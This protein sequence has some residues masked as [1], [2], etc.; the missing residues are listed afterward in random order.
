MHG[1]QANIFYG[2][3]WRISRTAKWLAHP[4]HP[5]QQRVLCPC[6]VEQ[7]SLLREWR[8]WGVHVTLPSSPTAPG[9]ALSAPR[10]APRS[11]GPPRSCG[12]LDAMA[13]L[14]SSGEL[15]RRPRQVG[16][17]V[18]AAVNITPSGPAG[19]ALPGCTQEA[20]SRAWSC[21]PVWGCYLRPES[22]QARL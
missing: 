21:A 2:T 22:H 9:R 6:V 11:A 18:E 15:G 1:H 16:A 17:V 8:A 13:D 5:S 20:P 12:A 3:N 10:S 19:A 14:I 7:A 4:R